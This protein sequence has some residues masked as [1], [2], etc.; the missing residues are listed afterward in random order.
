MFADDATAMTW[1]T[2]NIMMCKGPNGESIAWK[3]RARIIVNN[4]HIL[5]NALYWLNDKYPQRFTWSV[6][7]KLLKMP[8]AYLRELFYDNKT[9]PMYTI[10]DAMDWVRAKLPSWKFPEDTR[11]NREWDMKF[12]YPRS[13]RQ[14]E[15]NE[16]KRKAAAAVAAAAPSSSSFRSASSFVRAHSPP[17]PAFVKDSSSVVKPSV[18]DRKVASQILAKYNAWS[19][20]KILTPLQL[21][22]RAQKAAFQRKFKGRKFKS[23]WQK[24]SKQGKFKRPSFKKKWNWSRKRMGIKKL[25]IGVP[26]T[27]KLREKIDWLS[28]LIN[29]SWANLSIAQADRMMRAKAF[30]D[31]LVK[32]ASGLFTMTGGLPDDVNMIGQGQTDLRTGPV[33]NTLG[34]N[35]LSHAATDDDMLAMLLPEA[36]GITDLITGDALPKEDNAGIKSTAGKGHKTR[37]VMTGA[38]AKWLPYIKRNDRSTFDDLMMIIKSDKYT[39]REKRKKVQKVYEALTKNGGAPLEDPDDE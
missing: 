14:L 31:K 18:M 25:P 39:E 13:M 1:P 15:E 24:T 26:K 29:K 4:K 3:Q 21:R 33:Q 8:D 11:A 9:W 32:K 19:K 5:V 23:Y 10:A 12:P 22:A 30:H 28:N 7:S 20:K 2:H 37:L 35:L 36:D 27:M 34:Q 38:A 6:G 16:Q 17:G